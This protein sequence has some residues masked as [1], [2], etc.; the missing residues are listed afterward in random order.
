MSW[1]TERAQGS[2]RVSVSRAFSPAH[3]RDAR[4]GSDNDLTAQT[5]KRKRWR[6]PE[7]RGFGFRQSPSLA[8]RRAARARARATPRPT[9]PVDARRRARSAGVGAHRPLRGAD[10]TPPDRTERRLAQTL[11]QV[12]KHRSAFAI[13]VTFLATIP[14]YNAAR[15][16]A[17]VERRL[18]A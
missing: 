12:A 4:R 11:V 1:D 8:L 7:Q 9:S 5:R 13:H 17:I 2:L 14:W 3:G 18:V 15:I 16:Q 10:A 6:R